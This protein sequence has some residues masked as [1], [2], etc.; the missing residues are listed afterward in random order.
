M[1]NN[2]YLTK[3]GLAVHCAYQMFRDRHSDAMVLRALRAWFGDVSIHGNLPWDAEQVH[4][5]G[6]C[7]EAIYRKS[8]ETLPPTNDKHK[9]A[10]IASECQGYYDAG[11]PGFPHASMDS[12]R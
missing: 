9:L 3:L 2:E 1:T 10:G 11:R 5:V 4:E 12:A 7:Y 8:H 6:E